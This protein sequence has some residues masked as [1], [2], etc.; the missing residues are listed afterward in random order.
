MD[1]DYENILIMG[2][3]ASGQA[4]ESVCKKIGVNYT[5]YDGAKKID[6]GK[7]ISHLSHKFIRNFDLIVV[8][9]GISVYNKYLVYAERMGIK[10]IG[11]LEFGYWFTSSPI[12]AITGTN[13]KTTTTSLVADIL[14]TK[15][16]TAAYGNIGKPLSLAYG[17][18][19]DYLVCEVSSFQLETTNL[20]RPYISVI[21][22][23]AEDHIDR[24]KTFD[25]Y[26]K[27]KLGLLKNC[28]EKSI[29]VLNADDQLLM[30]KTENILAKKYYISKYE[31]VH[32][33]YVRNGKIYSS[34]SRMTGEI[35]SVDDLGANVIVLEDILAAILVGI[36]AKCDRDAIVSAVKQFQPA[37][38]RLQTVRECGGVKYID[39]SKSTNIHSTMNA[40]SCVGDGVV[41]LLGGKDKNLNFDAIF[42]KYGT[43]IIRVFAF[44]S[45]RKKI[46]SS[47]KRCS[48]DSIVQY[49]SFFDAV[50]AACQYATEHN[51][52][53]LSPACASFD[54]FHS[55][56]ERGDA[57]ADI[58]KEMSNAKI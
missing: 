57:F 13:G 27:C 16:C 41:L 42:T 6:G 4:V 22:N 12:V 24:H 36:L 44:G 21:L 29:V 17:V 40:L 45:A 48:Y 7:Y 39:D 20:F 34:I 26:V 2:Y 50:R 10:I 53:L 5:I 38:H 8:S 49:K 54:E 43:K 23:I 3:G 30:S 51:I 47:A 33:V 56:A 46:M 11:E 55:Y 58:V 19:Y 14:A 37:P 9:P 35:I 28:N 31:K 25:N 15:Y 18:D 1:F 52:I 32:G